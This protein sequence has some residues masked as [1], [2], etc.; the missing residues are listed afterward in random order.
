MKDIIERIENILRDYDT[1][2]V[3]EAWLEIEIIPQE[4]TTTVKLV[5]DDSIKLE[6]DADLETGLKRIEEYLKDYTA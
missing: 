5:T 2:G 3:L 6:V 1:R 4:W